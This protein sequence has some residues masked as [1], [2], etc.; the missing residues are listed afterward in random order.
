MP[1]TPDRRPG[2]ADE[3]GIDFETTSAAVAAGQVRYDG[4]S[5]SFYD[6]LG[7]YDP[8]SGGLD[9]DDVLIDDVTSQAIVDDVAGNILV[10][11]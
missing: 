5:F 8:R 1:R 9:I 2:V 7:E 4:T 6:A 3:E 10:D 11:Q